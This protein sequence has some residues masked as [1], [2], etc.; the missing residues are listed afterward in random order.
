MVALASEAF[1][2]LFHP[3]TPCSA[4]K[5]GGSLHAKHS[6]CIKTTPPRAR[7]KS[8][9]STAA[10]AALLAAVR[11]WCAPNLHL[12]YPGEKNHDRPS[13]FAV[14]CICL[15]PRKQKQ[16]PVASK[17]KTNRG[18]YE[19]YS[20]ANGRKGPTFPRKTLQHLSSPQ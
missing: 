13:S 9:F 6:G 1:F 4:K 14:Q 10:Q 3:T 19:Q 16:S 12:Q 18:K 5:L 11:A 2:A 8:A 15:R 20:S 7:R 17:R